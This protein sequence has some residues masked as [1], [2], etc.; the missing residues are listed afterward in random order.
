MNHPSH[1]APR[2]LR[3]FAPLALA[4]LQLACT[5]LP[6]PPSTYAPTPSAPRPG[7]AYCSEFESAASARRSEYLVGGVAVLLAGLGVAA[8]GMA[9]YIHSAE[10]EDPWP[11]RARREPGK[12][13]GTVVV[14]S[15]VVS[16]AV[17]ILPFMW[18]AQDATSLRNASA[19]GAAL[20]DDRKAYERC[21]RAYEGDVGL[22]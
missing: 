16:G 22:D 5:A 14:V 4:A 13:E 19:R 7:L 3:T 6:A 2:A 1:R 8:G 20:P 17:G 18:F 21:V 15:G 11:E 9:H 12:K 10:L